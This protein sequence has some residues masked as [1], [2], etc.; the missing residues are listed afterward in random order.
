MGIRE[1]FL[2]R[3]KSI[4]DADVIRLAQVA[5]AKWLSNTELT[6]MESQ[7]IRTCVDWGEISWMA[8]DVLVH[9][10]RK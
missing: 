1:D 2:S 10:S 9:F 5:Q 6:Y 4:F 7:A 8:D 3:I